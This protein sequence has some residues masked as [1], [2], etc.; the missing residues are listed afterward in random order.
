M[1]KVPNHK[2]SADTI[3]EVISCLNSDNTKDITHIAAFA[4]VSLSC[5]KDAIA[6][7]KMIDALDE[8]SILSE[9]VKKLSKKYIY[10]ANAVDLLKEILLIWKPFLL[11]L[12]YT[13]Q[14]YTSTNCIKKISYFYEIDKINLLAE[15]FTKWV[16]ELNIEI[17]VDAGAICDGRIIDNQYSNTI[18]IC[19]VLTEDV[20]LFIDDDVK[21]NLV[22]AVCNFNIPD[23]SIN[24]AGKAFEDFLRLIDK[25]KNSTSCNT[26][27]ITQLAN[28][29]KGNSIIHQKHNKIAEAI[30]DIR[31]MTGHSKEKDTLL[32][33]KIT[34]NGA[35]AYLHLVVSNMNSI[36]SYVINQVQLF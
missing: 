34:R 26:N 21:N 25:K 32:A 22:S 8:N 9:Y 33:W 7:L 4:G 24:D 2:V 29:L 13:K 31:N 30:G 28:S 20:F 5:V 16:K 10:K 3:Y 14:G 12:S 19:D 23:K 15:I 17:K 6:T 18:Y 36:Y 11:F 1:I 27:G 35:I